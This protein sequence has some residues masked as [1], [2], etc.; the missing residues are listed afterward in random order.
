MLLK[1]WR[2]HAV[3]CKN[4]IRL[5]ASRM[6]I[7]PPCPPVAGKFPSI[8]F[9]LHATGGHSGTIYHWRPVQCKAASFFKHAARRII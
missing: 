8:F 1:N 9:I 3:A 6:Q 2:L 4:S 5:V 7:V